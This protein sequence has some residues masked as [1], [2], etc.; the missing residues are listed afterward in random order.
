MAGVDC[1]LCHKRFKNK[2]SYSSHRN[3][4]HDGDVGR[5]ESLPCPVSSCGAKYQ[6]RDKFEIHLSKHKALDDTYLCPRC[7]KTFDSLK[8]LSEHVDEHDN[9]QSQESADSTPDDHA[10]TVQALKGALISHTGN[11][12]TAEFLMTIT[13]PIVLVLDDNTQVAVLATPNLTERLAGRRIVAAKEIPELRLGV[14]TRLE[15]STNADLSH[16]LLAHN[17][18]KIVLDDLDGYEELD[19]EMCQQR[20]SAAAQKI[21][22]RLAGA[23][24]QSKASVLLVL[25][26][27]I[28]GRERTE[29]PH[30]QPLAFPL[31]GSYIVESVSHD[32]AKKIVIGTDSWLA[33]ITS[34]V[35]LNTGEVVVGPHNTHF[36]PHKHSTVWL[37]TADYERN[38]VVERQ[39]RSK[40]HDDK[41]YMECAGVFFL[42]QRPACLPVTLRTLLEHYLSKADSG[43]K[44]VAAI[45]RQLYEEKALSRTGLAQQTSKI[46]NEQTRISQEIR[47]LHQMLLT[48][49]HADKDM[50]SVSESV[51]RQ[52]R[53]LTEFTTSATTALNHSVVKEAIEHR[54]RVILNEK[55]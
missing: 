17:Y 15:K 38:S 20:F 50:V 36:A 33:L 19:N 28:Y 54:I 21:A 5:L 31:L 14:N 42:F 18:G 2:N 9:S 25:K 53:V 43:I 37:R 52:L 39:L 47:T 55:K 16:S 24:V 41:T 8:N 30:E 22:R 13:R 48:A 4:I 44:T 11:L 3:D 49:N 29:D 34:C 10:D 7:D 1:A 12:H 23:L 32:G 26:V 51:S 35:L 6:S 27:E 40:Y 46:I 45:F